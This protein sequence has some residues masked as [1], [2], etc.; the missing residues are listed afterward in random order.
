MGSDVVIGPA[1]IFEQKSKDLTIYR[2]HMHDWMYSLEELRCD[3][4]A[5]SEAVN[6]LT[7]EWG[8]VADGVIALREAV[9]ELYRS[10]IDRSKL[11]H[12]RAAHDLVA[13]YV[14]PAT[15]SRWAR[16]RRDFRDVE[17]PRP[18]ID[19]VAPDEFPLS[20]FYSSLRA[21]LEPVLRR[22]GAPVPA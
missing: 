3:L 10:G 16:D 4:T 11:A 1:P 9:A 20:I 19:L 15:G 18:Y 7:V 6:R 2:V 22:D 21:K 14:A 5:F 12:W 13:T 8:S 17:D